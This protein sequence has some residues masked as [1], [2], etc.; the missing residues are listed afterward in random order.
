MMIG[1]KP[2]P[3]DGGRYSEG[4][5][6]RVLRILVVL[7]LIAGHGLYGFGQTKVLRLGKLID[8]KGKVWTDA[9]VV[10]EGYRI[11]NV[12]AFGSSTPAGAE[13]TDLSRYTGI[14]GL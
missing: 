6:M 5:S 4:L 10:I 13:V 7:V 12:G 9:V 14:P 3:F 11:K 2:A 1:T 8:G